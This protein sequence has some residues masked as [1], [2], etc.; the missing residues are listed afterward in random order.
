MCGRT[1][2]ERLC[3]LVGG[4]YRTVAGRS[5]RSAAVAALRLAVA[6][7]CTRKGHTPLP[8]AA[9]AAEAGKGYWSLLGCVC[10]CVRPS[11]GRRYSLRV[12]D[13]AV[14]WTHTLPSAVFASP[15]DG[16][17]NAAACAIIKLKRKL[18][19]RSMLEGH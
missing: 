9:T 4:C 3:C 17:L 11:I 13:G 2:I 16:P 10:V 7:H 1:L 6:L 12:A 8:T 14:E 15:T 5:G 18:G 19:L